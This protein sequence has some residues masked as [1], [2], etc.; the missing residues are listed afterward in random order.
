MASSVMDNPFIV[1][2]LK[3]L[4]P[5][6][7]KKLVPILEQIQKFIDDGTIDKL[8]EVVDKITTIEQACVLMSARLEELEKHHGY[9]TVSLSDR[10]TDCGNRCNRISEGDARNSG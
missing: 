9:S 2:T 6:M 3:I 10:D 7:E 8:V 5:I 4:S 1:A